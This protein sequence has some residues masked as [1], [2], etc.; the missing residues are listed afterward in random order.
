MNKMK[1][2][3]VYLLIIWIHT[4]QSAK[5]LGFFWHVTDFHYDANYS[6]AGDPNDMCHKG[7]QSSPSNI[8]NYGNYLCD[9]PWQLITSAVQAMYKIQPDPD[10][11]IWTGDSVPHV[12]D[13]DLNLDKVYTLIGNVTDELIAVFPNTTIYPVLG[14]HDPYP[15]NMMPY[16]VENDKY[17]KG[18]LSVS[19]WQAVL[20]QN[21][22]EQFR[23]G[24]YYSSHI[25]KKIKLLGLNTNLYYSQDKLTKGLP[26]PANQFMWLS[27]QLESARKKN[28]QVYIIAHVPPG[29]FELVEGMSWFY[30]EYNKK[31]LE[32]LEKYSDVIAAQLYGHEH[33]DSLRVQF[34]KEGKPI[35]ALFLSPA[36][37]PWKSTLPGVGAN[38]PS[39]RLFQYD[40]ENGVLK[41]YI[42]Y[43]LNLT[44]ANM[45]GDP[46]KWVKE[47]DTSDVY[48]IDELKPRE[49]HEVIKG[50]SDKSNMVFKRYLDFNSVKWSTNQDCNDTC[51][52]R[53]ICAMTELDFDN[54][55]T[56]M[57]GEKTTT[58]PETTTCHHHHWTT[59]VPQVPQYMYYVIGSL[60][61]VLFILF[62]VVAFMCFRKGRR[63][64][65]PKYA[66][67][68]SLSVNNAN[69]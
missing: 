4:S 28:E 53:H 26:D 40:R 65:A 10:F 31:Y 3:T 9:A 8:G 51:F 25:S 20:G 27:N 21:E 16:D 62:L 22:S 52:A 36:V 56:C 48:A 29:I 33:T 54:Y 30:A 13:K 44:E 49:I 60:A 32:V 23:N 67:F 11:I 19:G 47:Y 5:N 58:R 61:G 64:S 42:Q 18:I 12:S 43:Y 15:A 37:T 69:A 34:D 46:T 66:K 55:K 68:G 24:G 57:S 59:P 39:I 41:K 7:N 35:G 14:N 2:L 63:I 50:F 38:N 17:Y 1:L 45:K 6:T